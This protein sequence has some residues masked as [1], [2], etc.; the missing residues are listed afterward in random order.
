[1]KKYTLL[2]LA[3]PVLNACNN[4]RPMEALPNIG[5][6]V[7]GKETCNTDIGKDYWLV[8]F[9]VYATYPQ[10][11]DTLVL[12][13]ITYTNVL[14]VKGLAERLK[15]IGMRVSIDY[16]TVSTNRV[17]TTDCNVTTPI[18]YLLKELFIINQGEIR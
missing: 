14:K 7:I 13:G 10:I 1:M 9:T 16:T 5:G 17:A 6:Y 8:D 15:E 3:F 2:L 12:N 11:G 4:K 18:T